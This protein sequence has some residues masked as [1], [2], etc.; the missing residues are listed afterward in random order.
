MLAARAARS[1]L[2]ATRMISPVPGGP[3]GAAGCGG[4]CR[5]G[6]SRAGVGGCASGR[7]RPAAVLASLAARADGAADSEEAA[8]HTRDACVS[9]SVCDNLAL[10]SRSHS[11]LTLVLL[12]SYS[13]VHARQSRIECVRRACLRTCVCVCVCTHTHLIAGGEHHDAAPAL[14]RPAA[15]PVHLLPPPA[16]RT[17]HLSKGVCPSHLTEPCPSPATHTPQSPLRPPGTPPHAYAFPEHTRPPPPTHPPNTHTSPEHPRAAADPV[18]PQP[19]HAPQGPG[20][21][22]RSRP[23]G[24]RG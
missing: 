10:S 6:G 17:P 1:G 8:P 21:A 16:T 13:L 18:H 5:A 23:G 24:G 19:A 4:A 2:Y 22:Q 3:P 11:H 15:H 20:P 14:P 12:A 9:D 7:R